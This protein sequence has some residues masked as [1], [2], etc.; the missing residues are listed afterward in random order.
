MERDRVRQMGVAIDDALKAADIEGRFDVKLTG[1]RGS[2]GS[3]SVKFSVE[4]SEVTDGTVMTPAAVALGEWHSLI[5]FSENPLGKTF[6]DPRQNKQYKIVGYNRRASRFPMEVERVTDGKRY[7]FPLDTVIRLTGLRRE[8]P[9]NAPVL[10]E[11]PD[12]DKLAGGS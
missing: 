4:L 8:S 7:K 1:A 3:T 6:V 11:T 9:P 12:A 2:Y 10:G 5:G